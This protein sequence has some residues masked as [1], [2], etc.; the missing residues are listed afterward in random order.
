MIFTKS[1]D[2]KN[3]II[4]LMNRE[5]KLNCKSMRKDDVVLEAK[6]YHEIL[7][8]EMLEALKCQIDSSCVILGS[9]SINIHT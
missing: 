8:R 7:F 2:G 4:F 1:N 5:T 9:N 3:V 6:A